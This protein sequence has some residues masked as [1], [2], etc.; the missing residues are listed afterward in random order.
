MSQHNSDSRILSILAGGENMRF[1]VDPE[2]VLCGAVTRAFTYSKN[3]SN[4]SWIL[5]VRFPSGDGMRLSGVA[6]AD[7]VVFISSI[8]FVS[9]EETVSI[10]AV[11][12]E[13]VVEA[14]GNLSALPARLKRNLASLPARTAVSGGSDFSCRQ[15]FE[16]SKDALFFGV[17]GGESGGP[18]RDGFNTLALLF[19]SNLDGEPCS[20]MMRSMV[21]FV[22]G[23]VVVSS[24]VDIYG[25][26]EKN[27]KVKYNLGLGRHVSSDCFLT[28][29]GRTCPSLKV[30]FD[31]ADQLAGLYS[32][33]RR[34]KTGLGKPRSK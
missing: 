26:D 16:L 4:D 12:A 33:Q 25:L 27:V 17:E 2:N 32:K 28:H 15:L 13:T 18:Y 9:G 11:G 22:D 21:P 19:T 6:S 34:K 7:N 1:L 20:V 10:P 8:V 5:S 24:S 23:K 3:E 29:D 14:L 31:L 30:A